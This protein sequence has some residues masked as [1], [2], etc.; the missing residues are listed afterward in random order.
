MLIYCYF[1]LIWNVIFCLDFLPPF[2]S[3]LAWETT[4]HLKTTK[5]YLVNYHSTH[6]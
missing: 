1:Q 5:L 6:M 4:K 3:E 2:P